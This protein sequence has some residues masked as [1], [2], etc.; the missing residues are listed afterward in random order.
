[1]KHNIQHSDLHFGHDGLTYT[2][3]MQLKHAYLYRCLGFEKMQIKHQKGLF[4]L[5]TLLFTG[6]DRLPACHLHP[7]QGI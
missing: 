4:S 6:T 2:D 5:S 1:M 7:Q 3:I